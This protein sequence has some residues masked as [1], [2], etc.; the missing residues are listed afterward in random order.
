MSNIKNIALQLDFMKLICDI[1][2]LYYLLHYYESRYASVIWTHCNF[3]L[4]FTV[5]LTV[6]ARQYPPPFVQRDRER[7]Q[8]V[9][10]KETGE[11]KI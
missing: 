1:I 9:V 2:I 5:A 10:A 3:Q 11:R 7:E 6:K 8:L 4:V